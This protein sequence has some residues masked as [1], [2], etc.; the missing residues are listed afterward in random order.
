[1]VAVCLAVHVIT[2]WQGLRVA[3]ANSKS[4]SDFM[5]YEPALQRFVVCAHTRLEKD[6][7]YTVSQAAEI[8]GMDYNTIHRYVYSELNEVNLRM[9]S[10]KKIVPKRECGCFDGLVVDPPE[11]PQGN[12]DPSAGISVDLT[13]G[14]G[15]VGGSLLALDG[16]RRLF[17]GNQLGATELALGVSVGLLSVFL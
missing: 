6:R 8:C 4:E 2:V 13:R 3:L 16:T 17:H 5:P 9:P 15:V 11:S 14:I 1:M 12:S 7:P 10:P